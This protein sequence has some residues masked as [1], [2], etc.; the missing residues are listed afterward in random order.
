[1]PAGLTQRSPCA[2]CSPEA[3]PHGT[4]RWILRL[5]LRHSSISAGRSRWYTLP[6][7]RR[8]LVYLKHYWPRP[9]PHRKDARAALANSLGDLPGWFDP[10]APEPAANDFQAQANNQFLWAQQVDFPF[11]FAF[12]AELEFRAGGNPSW[13]TGVDYRKQF[14]HSTNKAEV[15]AL[16]TL[17]GLSLDDD[18]DT[19][20]KAA[21]ISADTNAVNYLEQNI[22][23]NGDID[24]PVLTMHTEGDGLVS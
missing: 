5:L 14:E 12:R 21:R 1:M 2:V 20:N 7:R 10:G 6:I 16:Y 9:T 24:F 13:N 23:F 11:I 4:R 19:L 8:I 22:V 18:L 3:W 15:R 17:A